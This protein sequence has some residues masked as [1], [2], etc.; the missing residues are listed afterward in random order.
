[1]KS[2]LLLLLSTVLFSCNQNDKNASALKEKEGLN[3]EKIDFKEKPIEFLKSKIDS[4]VNNDPDYLKKGYSMPFDYPVA[5]KLD[6]WNGKDSFYG[7]AY[8]SKIID[9][10]AYY[11][12]IYFNRIAF[13]T[14]NNKTV[15]ILADAEIKS[16]T[17]YNEFVKQLEKQ[18]GKPT[19]RPQ[20]TEDV[21][22]EW[23]AK[24]RRI[25]IDYSKGVS[26]EAM[27][28]KKT[29]VKQTFN[30]Q[31]LVFS[32]AEG[33]KIDSIQQKNYAKTKEYKVMQ[34]DFKL[35]KNDPQK[36]IVLMDSILN[37]KFK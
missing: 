37:E 27:S 34:G 20:T 22:Y 9:S 8:Y 10:I 3:L 31:M 18:F 6:A 15:A 11:Q 13:L 16:D 21:F 26:M 12:N 29:E 36:N 7:K 14:H 35:Y 17:V 23:S 25:Q 2:F 5:Y 24:D 28:G 32:R 33:A 1:M 19:F 30:M 4:N